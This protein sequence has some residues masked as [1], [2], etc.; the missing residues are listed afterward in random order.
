MPDRGRV[1]NC[2]TKKNVHLFEVAKDHDF[3]YVQRFFCSRRNV[4][5]SESRDPGETYQCEKKKAVGR[6]GLSKK[7]SRSTY[8]L[9]GM[10]IYLDS[11]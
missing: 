7:L 6:L 3:L 2:D 4:H 9:E 11:L 8:L 10:K 5:A 1:L